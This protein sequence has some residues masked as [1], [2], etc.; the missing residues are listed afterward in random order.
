LKSNLQKKSER[1]LIGLHDNTAAKKLTNEV[2]EGTEASTVRSS[3]NGTNS[4]PGDRSFDSTKEEFR[5]DVRDLAQ[6]KGNGWELELKRQAE[7]RNF[8]ALSKAFPGEVLAGALVAFC[9]ADYDH[10]VELEMHKRWAGAN[11][12]RRKV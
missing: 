10:A 2:S 8:N 3:T 4:I 1:A 11:Y 5:R 6:Q 7:E 12:L 9:K